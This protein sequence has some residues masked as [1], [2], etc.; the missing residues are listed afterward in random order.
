MQDILV[1]VFRRWNE[2]QARR[3]DS[4]PSLSVLSALKTYLLCVSLL[5]EVRDGA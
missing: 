3:H 2:G 5:G 4:G 1:A